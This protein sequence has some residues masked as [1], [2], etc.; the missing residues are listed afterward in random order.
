MKQSSVTLPVNHK[1]VAP[2]TSFIVD[3]FS[4]P[5]DP[6]FYINCDLMV[7]LIN[8]NK[9]MSAQID[10][11]LEDS[12]DVVFNGNSILKAEFVNSTTVRVTGPYADPTFDGL[13]LQTQTQL[14]QMEAIEAV[15]DSF[16][17]F[18]VTACNPTVSTI[19][20]VTAHYANFTLQRS[21]SIVDNA[22][23][24]AFVASYVPPSNG[25]DNGSIID[26]STN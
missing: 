3:C 24:E 5:T 8:T 26:N 9:V 15:K 13:N 22:K 4:N 18:N 14:C 17:V 6:E 10:S 23:Y 20:L 1:I 2:V 16:T 21:I 7:G 11:A 12:M 19:S 25:T